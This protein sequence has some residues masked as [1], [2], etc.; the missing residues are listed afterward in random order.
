[1]D[2]NM[3]DEE[4]RCWFAGC[5]LVGLTMRGEAWSPDEPWEIADDLL[6]VRNQEPK[7]EVGIVAAKPR[8]KKSA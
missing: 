2:S 3:N 6:A 8:R 7:Q 1:M 5:A 4:L